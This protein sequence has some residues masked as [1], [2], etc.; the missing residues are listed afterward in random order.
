MKELA[1]FGGIAGLEGSNV[2]TR[3]MLLKKYE[4]ILGGF[5]IN[6]RERNALKSFRDHG[7]DT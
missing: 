4:G 7:K 2:I 3:L 1:I 6:V 5:K